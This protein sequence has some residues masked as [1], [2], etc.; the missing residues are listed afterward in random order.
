MI[1]VTNTF[2]NAQSSAVRYVKGKV[3]LYRNSTLISTYTE[4]DDLKSFTID[5]VGG[6][7]KFYGTAYCQ[8][9]T[10]KLV[11]MPRG[12]TVNIGDVL[13][14][15]IGFGTEYINYPNFKV[16]DVK[17]DETDNL[18]T[19]TGYDVLYNDYTYADLNMGTSYTI[20]GLADAIASKLGITKQLINVQDNIFN[21]TYSGTANFSGKETLRDVLTAIAEA[22]QTICYVSYDNKLTFKRMLPSAIAVSTVNRSDYY[23]LTTAYT[24]RL[25]QICTVTELGDNIE[26]HTTGTGATQYIYENP[27]YNLRDDVGTLLTNAIGIIGGFTLSTFDMKWYGNVAL[28]L[29]DR[30]AIVGKDD[31]TIYSNIMNDSITYDGTLREETS[32]AFEEGSRV[33]ANSATI[34]DKLAM[35]SA[36]VD[37]VNQTITLRIEDVEGQISTIEMSADEIKSIV[38]GTAKYTA[39]GTA[40][41]NPTTGDIWEKTGTNPKEYYQWDGSMWASINENK[42]KQLKVVNS[43]SQTLDGVVYEGPSGT[44]VINGSYITTGTIDADKV[45]VSNLTANDIYMTGQITWNDFNNDAQSRINQ[46]KYY[47][48]DVK[49]YLSS[50]YKITSTTLNEAMISSPHIVGGLIEG[51]TLKVYNEYEV[52][53]DDGN[54]RGYIG[55]SYPISGVEI[56]SNDEES[57]LLVTDTYCRLQSGESSSSPAILLK[58]ATSSISLI[59]KIYL[60]DYSYGS[61]LPSSGNEEGR[62]FFVIE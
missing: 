47:D 19:I 39:S 23:D 12:I 13:K 42:A 43:I 11:D 24:Q 55:A 40:P 53:D 58:D 31:V 45:S 51:D 30:I 48:S 56:K 9:I 54:T 6:D 27:L 38:Q 3:G 37:K 59:G 25:R 32:F 62:L 46:G 21:L 33:D 52:C 57:F 50:K 17:R 18:L 2:L 35:T 29:G 49:S 14:A 44:T 22:T 60:D 4:S 16:I 20:G 8:K 61:T 7:N 5:R 28:E 36:K 26:A 10:C 15:Y 41:S 34:G 1:S